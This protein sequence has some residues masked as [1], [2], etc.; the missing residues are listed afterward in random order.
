MHVDAVRRI[1]PI[2]LHWQNQ[3]KGRRRLSSLS[4]SQVLLVIQLIKKRNRKKKLLLSLIIGMA[5]CGWF[6]I[7]RSIKRH[8]RN[9]GWRETVWTSCNEKRFKATLRITRQSFIY[10]LNLVRDERRKK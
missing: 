2:L 10:L 5:K 4:A 8:P 3:D 1:L 6:D 7:N 9:D